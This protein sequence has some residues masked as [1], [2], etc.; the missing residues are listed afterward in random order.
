MVW[1]ILA[2]VAILFA[3]IVVARLLLAR[4]GR[5]I[6]TTCLRISVLGLPRVNGR[7][8]IALLSDLHV[9]ALHVPFD[10]LVEA[11]DALEP[12]VLLLGG[13]YAAGYAYH[14]E[15]L[16]L[17]RRLS[18]G[19]PTFGVM[20]N[21]DRYQHFDEGPL[22][23]ILRASGGDLLVNEVGRIRVGDVT[24][25]ILGI[26]DPLHGSDD[27]AGTLSGTSD[28][29]DL[30]IALCHSPA[31]WWD[32]RQAGAAIT[33]FGHTH[34]GQIRLPRMEALV[35]HMTYPT[36]LAA[37]LFRDEDTGGDP[38]RLADHWEIVGM[39][40]ALDVSTAEGPLIYVTR[41]VGMGVVP[42]RVFCP[43]ELVCMDFNSEQPDGTGG[44]E[45]G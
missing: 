42:G 5:E 7:L 45:D 16:V 34:G 18:S 35:T 3:I 13:D 44:A 2:A 26:D 33:L 36:E 17:V 40:E 9:G 15:A 8:R 19:R 10:E 12:D 24:V 30:R 22:R 29:A 43:P 25:E 39:R 21:T 11:V 20:G 23:E 32:I 38:R 31:A 14:P 1:L 28:D 4:S 6:Q 37:G 27:V 41:G